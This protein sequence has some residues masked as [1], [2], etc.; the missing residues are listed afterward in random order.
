MLDSQKSGF[1]HET[2]FVIILDLLMMQ[3][4]CY[5]IR[6]DS[7][8][9]SS[10]FMLSLQG[11][12]HK[13]SLLEVWIQFSIFS[14]FICGLSCSWMVFY[15]ADWT[16]LRNNRNQLANKF[17]QFFKFSSIMKKILFSFPLFMLMCS[18]RDRKAEWTLWCIEYYV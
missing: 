15:A 9:L 4:M 17:Q 8:T 14:R 6:T 12:K 7:H 16:S 18:M 2:L 5:F 3:N 13:Y 1:I 11:F 10:H